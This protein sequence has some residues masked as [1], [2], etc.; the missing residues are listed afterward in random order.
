MI[1][2]GGL[3]TGSALRSCKLV[4][5]VQAVP[6]KCTGAQEVGYRSKPR[7]LRLWQGRKSS[8]TTSRIRESQGR[9]PNPCSGS[10]N[11]RTLAVLSTQAN[12]SDRAALSMQT[13][14]ESGE[15]C[16]GETSKC[17]QH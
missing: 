16:A 7:W 6:H 13:S 1:A 14:T 8:Q 17:T 11:W 3:N 15:E 12:L 4:C 9:E 5:V 2:A 10:T